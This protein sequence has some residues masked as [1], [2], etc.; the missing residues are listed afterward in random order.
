MVLDPNPDLA[1]S[2]TLAIGHVNVST[3][4]LHGDL[5]TPPQVSQVQVSKT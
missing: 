3:T 2:T 5:D 1:R 4:L